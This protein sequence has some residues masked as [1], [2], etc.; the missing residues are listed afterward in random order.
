MVLPPPLNQIAVIDGITSSSSSISHG[1]PQLGLVII[2]I[3]YFDLL[4]DYYYYYFYYLFMM[5]QTCL[6]Y[7]NV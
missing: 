4:L 3:N 2:I 5:C 1:V 6:L 7:P